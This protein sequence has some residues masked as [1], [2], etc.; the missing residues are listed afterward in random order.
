MTE[1]NLENESDEALLEVIREGS[2]EDLALLI[3]YLTD[4]GKGRISLSNDRCKRMVTARDRGK[5]SPV[6]HTII[7]DEIRAFGGN[8]FMNLFN[9]SKGASYL[10]ILRDVLKQLRVSYESNEDHLGLEQKLSLK[11]LSQVC[12][13]MSE[14]QLRELMEAVNPSGGLND[15]GSLFKAISG[16]RTLYL[17]LLEMLTVSVSPYLIARPVLGLVPLAFPVGAVL[18]TVLTTYGLARPAY[19]VTLPC[20]MHIAYMRQKKAAQNTFSTSTTTE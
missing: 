5:Y 2:A 11:L 20:T 6:I 19:R 18:G 15:L 14:K 13:S 4:E 10:S 9:P 8:T 1:R 16:S 7:Y 12:E 3:N 17:A